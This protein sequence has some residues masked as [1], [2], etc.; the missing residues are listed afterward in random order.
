MSQRRK[1]E[2]DPTFQ[3]VESDPAFFRDANQPP[4]FEGRNL[5]LADR[6]LQ[7]AASREGASWAHERLVGWG[8]LLG[9]AETFTLAARA[10]RYP[11]ELRTHD[12]FGERIDE[13][14]FDPAWH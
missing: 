8:E 9:R 13:V 14:V 6:A 1:V 12:R 11:P 7:D 4:P 2:S 5:Y 3:K 10:N